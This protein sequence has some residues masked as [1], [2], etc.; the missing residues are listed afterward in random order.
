MHIAPH[1]LRRFRRNTLG[2]SAVEFALVLPVFLALV[3]S[4][5]EAGWLMVQSIMI[6][7]ALDKT[8]RDLR[9][10]LIADTSMQNVR[11]I[12]CSKARVLIRCER[13]L[14]L[15]FIPITSAADYPTDNAR[16]IDRTSE[17]EPVLRFNP[18]ARMQTVYVR[19]CFVVNPITPFLGAGM[20][21]PVDQRGE[22]RLIATS[23]FANEP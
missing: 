10:G 23:A 2:A 18:G 4:T 7:H 22:H 9:I 17:I 13:S 16:C 3:L 8:I 21:L 12:V 20:S 14:A 1:P 15:E 5:F 19:A 6:D 11:K